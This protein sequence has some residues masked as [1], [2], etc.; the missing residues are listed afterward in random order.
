VVPPNKETIYGEYLPKDIAQSKGETR[1]EKFLVYM[2][3][4]SDVNILDLRPKL[5]NAKQHQQVYFS[6]DTHWNGYGLFFG[7][8]KLIESLKSC[9]PELSDPM[10]FN[11]EDFDIRPHVGDLIHLGG[12]DEKD[13]PE[14][15]QV[16]RSKQKYSFKQIQNRERWIVNALIRVEMQGY[17]R[18]SMHTSN[19]E[20]K[21]RMVM[22]HDSFMADMP[23][24]LARHFGD[25]YNLWLPA[26]Y[27]LLETA[28]KK[29]HPD[30]VIDEIAERML[31]K[32][33]PKNHPEWAAARKRFAE[34]MNHA[35]EE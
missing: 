16:F 13:Y 30:V 27:D 29:Y 8:Q 34:K 26:E 12:L 10:P 3:G 21:L 32:D 14:L 20:N 5:L 25:I 31:Y 28:V 9:F 18:V 22:F 24:L 35:A 17:E 19:P 7:Y 6:T 2:K 4:H 15:K 1:L 23:K 33:P 11:P